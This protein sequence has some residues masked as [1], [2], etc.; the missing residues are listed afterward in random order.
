M[1][2]CL[3]HYKVGTPVAGDT[4]GRS[5]PEA[6]ARD[7]Q[8]SGWLGGHSILSENIYVNALAHLNLLDRS[9]GDSFCQRVM[10]S[11][12]TECGLF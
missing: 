9:A 2:A 5:R 6:A 8:L 10:Q 3:S 4:I 1:S 12:Q 7:G 11:T